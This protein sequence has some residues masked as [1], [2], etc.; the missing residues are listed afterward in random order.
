[1][2]GETSILLI[3]LGISLIYYLVQPQKINHFYGYRTKKSMKNIENWKKA[4][5]LASKGLLYLMAINVLLSI[6][7]TQFLKLS[8]LKILA[9]ILI[10]EFIGLFYFVEKSLD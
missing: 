3:L 7:L 1:M 6:L 10:I 5:N 9:V 8:S 4:N 2:S